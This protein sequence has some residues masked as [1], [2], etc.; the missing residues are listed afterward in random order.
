[1]KPNKKTFAILIFVICAI[2]G[3]IFVVRFVFGGPEDTWIKQNGEW[4]KHGNPSEP[5]PQ[6]EKEIS[7]YLCPETY[8]NC[9]PGP[10]RT[11]EDKERM[12]K[13]N[14]KEYLDWI[15]QNCPGKNLIVY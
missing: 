14:N 3:V 8:L 12:E 13:C 5:R 10:V 7:R 2:F 15:N 4:V 9:M 6:E 1:M 11:P